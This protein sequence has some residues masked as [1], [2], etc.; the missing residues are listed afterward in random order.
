MASKQTN[1]QRHAYLIE[2]IMTQEELDTWYGPKQI[3]DLE[4][5]LLNP[6]P[7]PVPEVPEEE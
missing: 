4:Y 3:N 5:R 7:T 1:D 6:R 2:T